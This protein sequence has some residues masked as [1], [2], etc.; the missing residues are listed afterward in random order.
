MFSI[1]IDSA[2]EKLVILDKH[3]NFCSLSSLLILVRVFVTYLHVNYISKFRR[4]NP[5]AI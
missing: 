5:E 4:F 2:L 3:I 1:N